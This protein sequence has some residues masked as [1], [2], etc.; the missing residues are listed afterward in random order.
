[1][2][3]YILQEFSLCQSNLTVANAKDFI[4]TRK[5][6]SEPHSS[7]IYNIEIDYLSMVFPHSISSLNATGSI[8]IVGN[9]FESRK[10]K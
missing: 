7:E 3:I 1:M 8:R 9:R 2:K 10:Q 4:Q 6:L 5:K